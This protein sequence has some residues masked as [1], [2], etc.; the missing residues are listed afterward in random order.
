MNL[1][2]SFNGNYRFLSNFAPCKVEYDGCIYPSTEHAYQAAKTLSATA[3]KQLRD[4]ESPSKAKKLGRKVVLRPDWE[5]IKFDVMEELLRKKFNQ[6]DFKR[7]LLATGDA[8][9]VEGNTWGD[10]VWGVC[11]G[12]GSNHL[13]K[14]L[15]KI[16]TELKNRS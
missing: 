14:L 6:P 15:M 12:K 9:L 13:G 8:E 1:I 7:A 16:R 5:N 10:T 2:E 3:R 4:C 11:K